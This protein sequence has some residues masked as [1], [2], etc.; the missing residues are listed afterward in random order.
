ML[1]PTPDAIRAPVRP[2]A[3]AQAAADAAAAKEDKLDRGHP[4]WLAL[5]LTVILPVVVIILWQLAYNAKVVSPLV[6]PRPLDVVTALSSGLI[7]GIW[8]R[9]I[10]ATVQATVL[11][12]LVGFSVAIVV[13]SC[14][15]FSALARETLYP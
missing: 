12:F 5:V 8:W 4:R 10:L 13:G 15:A 2:A 6:I 9:H 14:F 7:D 1:S 11:A 3:S